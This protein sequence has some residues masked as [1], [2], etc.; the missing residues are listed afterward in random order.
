MPTRQ[1]YV[2]RH[3]DALGDSSVAPLSPLGIRQTKQAADF[4]KQE[5]GSA[6][7][8]VL[9]SPFLRATQS[10][11]LICK[12]I[13]SE[14]EQDD[15]LKERELGNL[16]DVHGDIW[17]HLKKHFQQDDLRFPNGESNREVTE[18][19]RSLL[20]ELRGINSEDHVILVTH[21]ITTT[22]L[23]HEFDQAI[24]YEHC[25]AMQNA[26]IYRVAETDNVRRVERIWRMPTLT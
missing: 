21:R 5:L 14:Y 22:L 13:G 17:E 3:G 20:N 8:R 10:A 7:I 23:L 26:D 25:K 2:I 9:S 18:R 11:D 16:T 24:G 15:R 19:V 4:L 12:A 1:I 6:S